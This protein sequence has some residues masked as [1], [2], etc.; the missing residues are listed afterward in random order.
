MLANK[1]Q[2]IEQ[3]LQQA[4]APTKLQVIDE[5]AQHAGHPAV[6]GHSGAS[7]FHVMIAS[8]QFSGKTTVQCHQMVYRAL[9]NLMD[10]EIHAFGLLEEFKATLKVLERTFPSYFAGLW[11]MYQTPSKEGL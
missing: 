3:L 1:Q 4:L 11:K 7:H 2:H 6:Q 9:G 5:S 10:K 8:E